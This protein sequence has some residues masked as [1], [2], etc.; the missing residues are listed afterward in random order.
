M[1]RRRALTAEGR[2][3][4]TQRLG[5]LLYLRNY[6]VGEK[7]LV[8]GKPTIEAAD[9]RIG[10]ELRLYSKLRTSRIAGS[11]AIRIGNR[12]FINHGVSITSRASVTIEDEAGLA[13]DVLVLDNSGHEIEGNGVVA[14]RIV[15]GKGAWIGLRA[16][17]LPGVRVGQR[18]I[19]AAGAVVTTDVLP[20]TLVAG[21]PAR[22]IRE[23]A[24]PEGV[25]RAWSG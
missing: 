4:Y 1:D 25:T 15:V 18:S 5:G 9:L 24:Y 17:I 3:H 8:W 23:L 11:G 10:D 12:V 13:Q 19:V 21:N 2:R 16:I 7:P 6:D 20:E 14:K 22:A